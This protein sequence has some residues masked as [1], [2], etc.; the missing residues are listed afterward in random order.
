VQTWGPAPN[1]ADITAL[2][3]SAA[4]VPSNYPVATLILGAG[5]FVS[6]DISVGA[7]AGSIASGVVSVGSFDSSVP[8]ANVTAFG[9]N[10]AFINGAKLTSS[11]FVLAYND[12]DSGNL[13]VAVGT[14]DGSNN[15]SYGTPVEVVAQAAS[16]ISVAPLGAT[17]FALGYV[18][19]DNTVNLAIGLVSGSSVSFP[20]GS[21]TQLTS[22]GSA[23]LI[24]DL[25]ATLVA[26]VYN[27]ANNSGLA[28]ANTVSISGTT[29]SPGAAD[30]ASADTD[31][32]SAIAA[33]GG[34]SFVFA[35]AKL[36]AASETAGTTTVGTGYV[37]SR[38]IGSPAA[39]AGLSS[40]TFVSS[41]KGFGVFSVDADTLAISLSSSYQFP[42]TN[43]PYLLNGSILSYGAIAAISSS[44]FILNDVNFS[45]Y[46]GDTSGNVAQVQHQSLTGYW[47]YKLDS[48]HALATLLDIN[49]VAHARVIGIEPINNGPIG[50]SASAVSEGDQCTVTLAGGTVSGMTDQ[51]G[52]ALT[53]GA[54]Y[55]HNGD[56]SI[57]TANTGK[58]A[59][60]ALTTSELLIAA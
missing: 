35:T 24:V 26:A 27:D 10:N 2:F 20:D 30:T 44:L 18:G 29:P 58:K 22:N 39:L 48:G 53:P 36:Y 34:T 33:L 47:L 59:G 45:I 21:S 31:S 7:Q 5:Q 46:E 4:L 49:G 56:G 32:P 57:V 42:P 41:Y 9:L 54:T 14:I 38:L 25:S 13:T 50:F 28:T 8:S 37:N 12:P 15:I 60:V 52:D 19:A 16:S 6:F 3:D 55:Y 43:L 11:S 23:L 1:V 51:A 40:T 17:T